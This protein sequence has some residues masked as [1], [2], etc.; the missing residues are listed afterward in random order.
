M[1]LVSLDMFGHVDDVFTSAV[2]TRISSTNEYVDGIPATTE[3]SQSTHS[4]NIQPLS[5][6]EAA[7]LSIGGERIKDYRKFYI[8]DGTASK[9]TNADKWTIPGVDGLFKTSDLDNR[10]PFGRNYCKVIV[11]RIDNE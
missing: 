2:V 9:V 3:D 1:S 7:K 4:V 10:V 5:N 11:S 6:R 8:N